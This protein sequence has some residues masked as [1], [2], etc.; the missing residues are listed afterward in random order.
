MGNAGHELVHAAD[1]KNL[2][3]QMRNFKLGEKNDVENY[4]GGPEDVETTILKQTILTL[5]K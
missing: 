2:Q 4:P 1:N 3:M 5:K